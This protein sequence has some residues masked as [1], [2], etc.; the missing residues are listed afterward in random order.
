[1]AL[2]AA[3]LMAAGASGATGATGALGTAGGGSIMS[4]LMG[5]LGGGGGGGGDIISQL[6]GMLG[7]G[8]KKK[9]GGD[10]PT[11]P[12]VAP[13]VQKGMQDA[14][15]RGMSAQ[16]LLTQLTSRD[17]MVEKLLRERMGSRVR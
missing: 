5:M 15:E 2:A 4:Q 3:P 10:A 12:S 16:N 9:G 7:G 14:Y 13:V 17:T 1:M 11:Q 6:M 8:G